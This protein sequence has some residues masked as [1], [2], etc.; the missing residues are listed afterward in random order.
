MTT[1]Q[2]GQAARKLFDTQAAAEYLGDLKPNT[3]EGW[4]VQGIGP[5]YIKCGRLVRYTLADLDAYLDSRV[6]SSTSQ[7]AA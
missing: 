6:R 4:R 1:N 2:T 7:R 5:R 3:I